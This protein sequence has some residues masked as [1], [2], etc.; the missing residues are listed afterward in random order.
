[1]KKVSLLLSL[2][3]AILASCGGSGATEPAADSTATQETTQ[4]PAPVGVDAAE[5]DDTVQRLRNGSWVAEHKHENGKATVRFYGSLEEYSKAA[6]MV[7]LQGVDFEK[8]FR[9]SELQKTFVEGPVK[10][11]RKF[12]SI[13]EVVMTMTTGDKSY[14]CAMTREAV[15]AYTGKTFQDFTDD[16]G[17][18]FADKHVLDDAGRLAMFEK[19]VTVE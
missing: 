2:G 10:I 17:A 15:E 6:P 1:M 9:E 4:A 12:P 7:A 18:N 11:M 8:S 5:F 13:N 19:F 3:L 14:T 16:W